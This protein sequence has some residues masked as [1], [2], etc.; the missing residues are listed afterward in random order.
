MF[1]IAG[2]GHYN[3]SLRIELLRLRTELMLLSI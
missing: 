3:G 1:I 2:D